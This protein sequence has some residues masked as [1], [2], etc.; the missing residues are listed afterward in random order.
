M[1]EL[2]VGKI[3]QEVSDN[4]KSDPT[5]GDTSKLLINVVKGG[6]IFRRKPKIELSGSVDS[7]LIKLKIENQ[8]QDKYGEAVELDSSIRVD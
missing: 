1:S 3:L 4:L 5:L 2:T 8:L 6:S 7:D